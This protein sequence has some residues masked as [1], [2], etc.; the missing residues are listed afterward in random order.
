MLLAERGLA[1][2]TTGALAEA[3]G[4]KVGSLYYHFASRDELVSEVLAEGVR[5]A[6]H[7]VRE[8][9]AELGDDPDPVEAL[10]VALRHH[11]L[12]A[13]RDSAYTAA[14]IRIVG[15]L[16]PDLKER[17]QSLQRSYGRL[18]RSLFARLDESGSLR[19]G[20]D[21]VVVRMLIVGAMNWAVEWFR[22]DGALSAEDVAD[23]LEVLVLQGVLASDA[24]PAEGAAS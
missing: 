13:L 2:A 20:S 10:R 8:A 9:L 17:Q 18:W 24:E 15:H 19:P 1:E 4:L 23:Q 12:A 14:N 6:Q 5:R 7:S 22:S 3:A 11:L 21:P 16:S